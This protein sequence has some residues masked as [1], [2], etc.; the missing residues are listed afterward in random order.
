MTTVDAPN[1]HVVAVEG[2]FDDC[3]DLVK[4]MF[5]DAPFRERMQLT[6]VNSI[7]WA[8]VMAQVVYY[9][10][11]TDRAA[12]P[13]R[14]LRAQRQ[15]RQRVLGVDRP[16]DGRT[17]RPARGRV[18][19]QRHPRPLRERQ[20]HE[21]RA[22]R[23]VTQPSMDIQ[24]SSNFERLLF[25]MNGRDGGM[26]AEQLQRF[27]ATG[28]LSIE[29][30]QRAEFIDGTFRAGSPRRR[31]DPR[32]DAAHLCQHRDAARPALCR[33][34]RRR[35]A[36]AI[37]ARA[38]RGHP[39]HRT[40]GE[41]PRR[42]RSGPPACTRRC[43]RTSPTCSSGTNGSRVLANDLAVVERFVEPPSTAD[44]D[45]ELRRSTSQGASERR[46][47]GVNV[48]GMRCGWSPGSLQCSAFGFPNR[49]VSGS[50]RCSPGD[51]SPRRWGRRPFARPSARRV[52]PP[53]QESR[54]P[55]AAEAL[56]QSMLES[57]DKDQLLAIAQAL[58][59]KT[60]ARA[61]KATLITKILETTG[62]TG[63]RPAESNGTVDT[64][65]SNGHA[66]AAAA[67]P[68][69]APPAAA[70]AADD[71]ADHVAEV[72]LGPDGEPLADWEIE[73]MRSGEAPIDTTPVPAE[74]VASASRRRR[75]RRDGRR[76]RRRWQDGES[77]NSR[78]RR[79]RR[80]KNGRPDAPQGTDR[81]DGP[82]ERSTTAPER[83]PRR[84]CRARRVERA[85][86]PGTGGGVGLPR[87]ARRGLR[88][89]ARQRLPG[90]VATTP[91]SR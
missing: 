29:P 6:A 28:R 24:V 12:W 14:R 35:R 91:T 65:A 26:T 88:L 38:H 48:R 59:I 30:D 2:T 74:S 75:R 73:L 27:R 68:A 62:S 40:P 82:R 81:F 80:N 5:N 87:P 47:G 44:A 18:E 13:D 72:V 69:P 45:F 15:L 71:I 55:V 46:V 53:S 90:R 11:A 86:Q 4:A 83:R 3:Q 58:G 76:P 22:G 77:R 10:V 57:K 33:G 60:T 39:G 32:G 61:A 67:A 7:N 85:A 41:V 37:A 78:R 36:P 31:R 9:V 34:R 89:P 54:W 8:R 21:H 70:D 16:A 63:S 56:E 42:R 50:G 52:S 23:A 19:R 66:A 25:E 51:R 1:V 49:P 64:A 43:R 79:R 84:S 17:D 20:R